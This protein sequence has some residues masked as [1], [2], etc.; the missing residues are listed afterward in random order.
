MKIED[1]F[2]NTCAL[3]LIEIEMLKP[4]AKRNTKIKKECSC[5]TEGETKTFF[6]KSRA[7]VRL[8]ATETESGITY[9][10]NQLWRKDGV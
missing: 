9:N 4:H 8:E 3:A 6:H 5:L 2:I 10:I 1:D 7:L